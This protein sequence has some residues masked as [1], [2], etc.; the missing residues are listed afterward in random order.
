MTAPV[1]LLVGQKL[2]AGWEGVEVSRSLTSLCGAFSLTQSA[3]S[4][5]MDEAFLPIFPGDRVEVRLEG[6]PVMVAWVDKVSPKIGARSHS[7]AVAGREVTCDLVDCGLVLGS[8]AVVDK[9]K[10]GQA[11]ATGTWK[12]ITLPQLIAQLV[13]P[14]GL[15]Y[16][17]EGGADVGAAFPRFSAEPGDTIFQTITKATSIRGVLP[18]TTPSGA[19]ALIQEG[20]KRST[21]RLVYGVNVLSAGGDFDMKDR[22]SSYIVRGTCPTPPGASYFSANK[23][24][25]ST[26]TA[27]DPG[28]TRYRPMVVVG[29]GDMNHRAA[30]DKAS[31]EATT[32]AAKSSTLEVTVRGWTQTDGTLWE[33][34]RLVSV[35]IPYILGKGSQ[36]F[37]IS[38]VRYTYGSGGTVCVLSLVHPGAFK[39]LPE[40][41]KAQPG[42]IDAWASVRKAVRS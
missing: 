17:S 24:F 19:V 3:T 36:D 34:G 2:L 11:S 12:K 13:Q 1:Q 4:S 15:T 30:Q 6:N 33:C 42:T 32:R 9:A 23:S 7:I 28:V 26:G 21:D 25:H 20:K 41:K 29:G 39:K 40:N 5:S 22:F 35:E 38:Q 27:T 14:F 31:W 18:I 37:L 10:K 16:S 8:G